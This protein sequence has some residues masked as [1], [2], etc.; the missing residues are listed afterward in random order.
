MFGD[1]LKKQ[2]LKE[3]LFTKNRLV[4]HNEDTFEEI[5]SL[6]L[7]LMNVFVVVTL[8]SIFLIAIT[9]YII[10]FTPLREYIPG[11]ASTDLKKEATELALKSDSL[12]TNV[13]YNN[14]YL[15]GIKNVLN[16]KIEIAHI[17]KDSLLASQKKIPDELPTKATSEEIELREQLLKDDKYNVFEAAKPKV[18]FV[19]FPPAKGTIIQKFNL[20]NKH[21]GV[22]IALAKDTPIKAIAAGSVLFADWTPNNGYVVIIK[23]KEDIIS[24]Y[25]NM[26]DLTQSSGDAVKTGEVLG[27]AGSKG[28]LSKNTDLYFELWKEG[29]P[30]NP[31]QFIAFD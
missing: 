7:N 8:S 1:R 13:A 30:I 22:R 28:Q 29:N 26:D 4:I 20:Q 18:G 27:L 24:I 23:H 2:L 25:K 19:L 15:E 12:A 3:K 11:Y 5:F 21:S 9:T 31:T 10:A 17:N 6:K 14:Q 16:G